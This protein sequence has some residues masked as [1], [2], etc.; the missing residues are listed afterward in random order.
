VAICYELLPFM[1]QAFCQGPKKK[2][3]RGRAGNRCR[4]AA[5]PSAN[6]G[7]LSAPMLQAPVSALASEVAAIEQAVGCVKLRQHRV[8]A[9][10]IRLVRG[11]VRRRLPAGQLANRPVQAS[12][13]YS[14][15]LTPYA[16][17]AG[18]PLLAL[19]DRRGRGRSSAAAW[20][21]LTL[22]RLGRAICGGHE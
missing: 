15:G 4:L 11:S 21:I 2:G 1:V 18:S 7:S 6:L 17:L 12:M 13:R 8:P 3:G 16:T 22:E 14:V 9:R 19:G 5:W 20:A 10:V